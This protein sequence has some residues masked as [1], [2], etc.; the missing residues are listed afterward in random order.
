MGSSSDYICPK[1]GYKVH[2]C[3]G[4][5]VGMF[6]VLKTFSCKECRTL[7]D[8]RIGEYGEDFPEMDLVGLKCPECDSKDV[9]PWDSIKRPCPKCGGMMKANPTL[10]VLW[11]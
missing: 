8:I 7:S 6:A 4:R 11:D 5:E 2:V 10:E 3:G 1:C 9:K